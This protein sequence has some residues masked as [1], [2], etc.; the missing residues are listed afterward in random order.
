MQQ[1]I[2][3]SDVGQYHNTLRNFKIYHDGD[4]IILHDNYGILLSTKS[5]IL[6]V[7]DKTIHITDSM[8]IIDNQIYNDNDTIDIKFNAL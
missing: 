1:L 7:G 4:S 6:N 3:R 8:I 5:G 2:P